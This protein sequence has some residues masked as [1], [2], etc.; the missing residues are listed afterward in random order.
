MAVLMVIDIS[1]DQKN[2]Y[3]TTLNLNDIECQEGYQKC[4]FNNKT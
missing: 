2:F 3:E 1:L 4:S